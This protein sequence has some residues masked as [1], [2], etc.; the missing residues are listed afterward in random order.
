MSDA[1]GLKHPPPSLHTATSAETI[2]LAWP[3]GFVQCTVRIAVG[4]HTFPSL[5]PTWL[6]AI[7]GVLSTWTSISG[8]SATLSAESLAR[9]ANL[10]VPSASRLVSTSVQ[11]DEP[12]VPPLAV[13]GAASRSSHVFVVV[14]TVVPPSRVS[15]SSEIPVA[16]LAVSPADWEPR[17]QPPSKS[18]PV[19]EPSVGL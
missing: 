4:A 1:A 7:G 19:S 12:D 8:V 3:P 6:G 18:V 11:D 9:P 15:T 13:H 2:G 17:N 16:S 5:A 10:C 14:F